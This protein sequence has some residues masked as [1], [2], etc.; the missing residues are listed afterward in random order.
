MK[1]PE[2]YKYNDYRE[3]L[4]DWLDFKKSSQSNFS[5]RG[6]SQKAGIA[7]GYINMVLTKKRNI[8]NKAL[9]KLL[10]HLK[11]QP[12]EVN[13]LRELIEFN[14]SSKHNLKI[15]SLNKMNQY[16]YY[17]ENSSELNVLQTYIKNWHYVTIREIMESS[18]KKLS[19]KDIYKKLKFKVN[20][21]E[22]EEVLDFLTKNNLNNSDNIRAEH[23]ESLR[24]S[25]SH[26]HQ[27]MLNKAVDSIYITER[28]SR[29]INAHVIGLD[30][31]NYEKAKDILQDALEEIIKMSESSDNK[32]DNKTIYN[33]S[34]LGFPLTEKGE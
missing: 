18:N 28:E 11:L 6:L 33:F 2:V 12:T 16:K 23:Q 31:K 32:N 13:F 22:I 5:I 7:T 4:K 15:K 30:K 29:F 14:D 3:F 24:V 26:F 1:K 25:M 17:R 21:N 9:D 34:V 19:A 27:D 8:T 20:I 10:P